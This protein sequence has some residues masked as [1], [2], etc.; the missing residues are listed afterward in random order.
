MNRMVINNIPLIRIPY[1]QKAITIND[2]KI[3]TTKFLLKES[4][5][6]KR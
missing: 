3:E 2:L 4:D 5:I 1:T 6:N